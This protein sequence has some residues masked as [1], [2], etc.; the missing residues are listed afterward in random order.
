MRAHGIG[1]RP[2]CFYD[3]DQIP[4]CHRKAV[5]LLGLRDHALRRVETDAELRIDIAVLRRAIEQ[6]RAAGQL[7]ICI[8]TDAAPPVCVCLAMKAE[9]RHR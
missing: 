7:P 6:D 4:S 1:E 9:K 5:E 2:L 8:I 3:S